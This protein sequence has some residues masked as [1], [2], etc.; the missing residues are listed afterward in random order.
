[1]TKKK[2]KSNEKLYDDLISSLW[3][4]FLFFIPKKEIP[5][6]F[7][8][9]HSK[10]EK[11]LDTIKKK[12]YA[13]AKQIAAIEKKV[14]KQVEDAVKFAEESPLPEGGELYQDVY[15]QKDYPFIKD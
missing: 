13:T 3:I 2:I 12:K 1:M 6:A 8:E 9:K 4:G 14:K 5:T 15:Q 11:V 7:L 10:L